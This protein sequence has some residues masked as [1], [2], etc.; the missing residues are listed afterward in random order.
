M[1]ITETPTKD[2]PG[3]GNLSVN[4]KLCRYAD[5]RASIHDANPISGRNT[6]FDGI[7]QGH[8][9]VVRFFLDIGADIEASGF[10]DLMPC[11]LDF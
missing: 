1:R 6:L 7:S 10:C 5:A 9:G 8:F 4:G 3:Q 11:D 2:T